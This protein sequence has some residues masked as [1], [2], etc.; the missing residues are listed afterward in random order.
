MPFILR[1][2]IKK[3]ILIAVF[4]LFFSAQL[5]FAASDSI[6]VGQD[7]TGTCNNN[8]ICEAGLGEDSTSCIADCPLPTPTPI[9][10][11]PAGGGGAIYTPDTKPPII[12][13]LLIE[14][15]TEN[16]AAI[17]WV[18]N[19]LAVCQFFWGMTE[20][21]E[22]ES[23]SEN[24][25]LV[26]HSIFLNDLST[27]SAYKYKI[28][29][30][31][32]NKNTNEEKGGFKSLALVDII[33]PANVGDFK[34]VAGDSRIFLSWKNPEDADFKEVKIFRGESFYPKRPEEGLLIYEGQK[35]SFS[36]SPLE[37][38]KKYY[39]TVFA[40]DFSGNFSSGALAHATPRK[41]FLPS[42]TPEATIAPTAAP[43]PA[44]SPAPTTISPF[45]V[46]S[47][48][49]VPI[50]TGILP[51]IEDIDLADFVFMQDGITI[52]RAGDT[53]EAD[54][55]K[56]LTIFADA[57]KIPKEVGAIMVI[58]SRDDEVF[59]FLLK[60]N[61]E[62]TKYET[63]ISPLKDEAYLLTIT[64]LDKENNI[65]KAITGQVINKKKTKAPE[66]FFSSNQYYFLLLILILIVVL[67]MRYY[68]KKRNKLRSER[69]R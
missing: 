4:L 33:P 27:D 5:V 39:Y 6:I 23:F 34:A 59:S 66:N 60:L 30:F 2:I 64:I 67:I 15:I 7:V 36:D 61:K 28:S 25:Y 41:K 1:F 13:K 40:Y 9:P 63:A 24:S 17:S 49:T 12:L 26:K 51:K 68:I 54:F 29:C 38:D 42:I 48:T 52:N 18:T 31:D 65:Y 8:G 32:A 50:P 19:E 62:K 21:Y 11:L 43:S 37:N 10:T 47:I 3:Y 46:P 57:E 69:H 55:D 56:P 58:L 14:N 45:P 16:S 53:I 35:I 44:I 22:T 20:E